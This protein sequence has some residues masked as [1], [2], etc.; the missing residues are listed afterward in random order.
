M[1]G[2]QIWFNY[3]LA[4]QQAD[5]LDRIAS[6]L[7]N[8]VRGD[9]EQGMG[10]TASGWHGDNAR[11]WQAKGQRLQD[12]VSASARHLQSAAEEVRAAARR[13][14]EIELANLAIVQNDST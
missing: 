6:Q 1:T 13:A 7:K 10:R 8:G 5:A 11:R 2:G 9:L 3:R 12:R 4:M 14:R